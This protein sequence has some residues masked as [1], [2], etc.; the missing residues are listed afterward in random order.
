MVPYLQSA[1][2]DMSW[3]LNK[4]Y[5]DGASL[6]LVGDR[7]RLTDRQRKVVMRGACTDHAAEN[8]KVK[9]ISKEELSGKEV[10]I[11]GFNVIIALETAMSGGYL[12]L[13]RDGL[14]RDNS[15]V[16]GSYRQVDE[17]LQCIQ[18]CGQFLEGVGANSIHWLLDQPVSNSG[19][20]LTAMYQLSEQGKWG[21]TVELV[22]SPD[23]ILK[24]V[25][26][27]IATSDAIILDQAEAWIDL[28]YWVCQQFIPAAH[29]IKLAP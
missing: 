11:D 18:W 15:S 26:G 25:D 24:Q 19:R 23:A 12:F 8:R 1:V 28:P 9:N 10:W 3:L 5:S 7:Y 21:W 17:T 27:V 6:K 20:L 14:L 29:I 13:G 2:A 16:H 4:G 22:P